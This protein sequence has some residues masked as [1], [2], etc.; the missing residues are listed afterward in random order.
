MTSPIEAASDSR[1]F[2]GQQPSLPATK[3][4]PVW[5]GALPLE[6]HPIHPSSGPSY[7]HR[8]CPASSVYFN[9][10]ND[11]PFDLE[12]MA[13]FLSILPLISLEVCPVVRASLIKHGK[14][15]R[16]G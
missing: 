15:G 16:D 11:P 14:R 13:P 4:R 7:P 9:F 1:V 10:V 12:D 5:A 2:N 8:I 3:S 6:Q